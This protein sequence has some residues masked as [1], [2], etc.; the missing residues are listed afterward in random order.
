MATMRGMSEQEQGR[1]WLALWTEVA[2]LVKKTGG[3]C[4]VIAKKTGPGPEDYKLEGMKQSG[5]MHIAELAGIPTVL[6]CYGGHGHGGGMGGGMSRGV[7]GGG[8]AGAG[9]A[10]YR[11]GHLAAERSQQAF[12]GR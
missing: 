7:Q 9:E 11:A 1:K 8:A 10:Q 12:H 4:F 6:C 3:K 5:E 2:K